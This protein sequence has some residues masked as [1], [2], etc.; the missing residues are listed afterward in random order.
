MTESLSN[1]SA[2]ITAT[3]SLI[4]FDAP[5]GGIFDSLSVP[6]TPTQDL[7]GYAKPWPG[8]GGENLLPMPITSGSYNYGVT[9]AVNPDFSFVI[10]KPNGSG[11][12]I[13]QL[14][15]FSLSAGTYTLIESDDGSANASIQILHED[16]TAFTNTRYAKRR[17]FTLSSTETVSATYS[18]AAAA[19]DVLTKIM[20]FAGN[21][22]TADDYSPYSNICPIS[23]IDNLS[24]YVSPT[25]Q[26]AQ[27]TE[28]AVSFGST[29][30]AGFVDPI[31]GE[32]KERPE[33]PSYNGEVLVGPWLSSMDEYAAGVT[34]T[35]GAQVVDLGGAL[36][37]ASI[38]PVDMPMLEGSNNVWVDTSAVITLIYRLLQV[39]RQ[40]GA[41]SIGRLAQSLLIANQFGAYSKVI[42]NV[43]KEL[44]YEAGNE[45]G[46]TLELTCPFGTQ[47]MANNILAM[48][49]GF[50]YQ[51]Y[52]AER[53]IL[54][55]AAELGDGL[56]V[57]GVYGG[58]FRLSIKSGAVYNADV[59]APADE[60]IDHEYAFIP[61]A[62]RKIERRINNL[63]SELS[64]QAGEIAA[65]VDREGGDPSSVSWT[66]DADV[67]KVA[68]DGS[69][70]LT[71]DENGLTVNGDGNFTGTVQAKNIAYGGSSGTMNGNG[72]TSRSIGTSRVSNGINTSLGNADF[73]ADV[74]S[75]AATANYMKANS[76]R[77]IG[78]QSFYVYGKQVVW[79][80]INYK[81]HAGVNSTLKVLVQGGVNP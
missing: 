5:S 77:V 69:D 9:V 47:A 22:K 49:E 3:G 45:T 24:V 18:R 28:Y 61:N 15:S 11:W 46:R 67:F 33:Y 63:S 55:P 78:G 23:G 37:T 75:G 27:A 59:S 19:T 34:P 68:V 26:Q 72:I 30:Y 62:E 25:T 31:T 66:M 42:L 6:I 70:V 35:T 1:Y 13:F 81:N 56:T 39:D 2:Q 71:V 53:A 79:S 12:T 8:G 57:N 40:T 58:I 38:T 60:E 32:V 43:T 16:G 4:T 74:F 76:V 54:D 48:L 50:Q 44:Y 10:N 21:T 29:V 20:L 51:P 65:K 36:S 17:V 14:G 52:T 80:T 41:T 73:S 64:V 7:H